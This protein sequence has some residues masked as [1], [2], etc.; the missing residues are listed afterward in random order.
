MTPTSRHTLLLAI[1]A[2]LAA[3]GDGAER[4]SRAAPAAPPPATKA[5]ATQSADDLPEVADPRRFLDTMPLRW[6]EWE[7]SSP[8]DRA[9]RL[10]ELGIA[11]IRRDSATGPV[12]EGYDPDGERV[13]DFHFVDF[14]GDGVADVIYDGAWFTVQEGSL[15]ALEGTHVKLYH[16]IGGRAVPVTEHHGSVQRIWKGGPGE[17]LSFRTMHH[18]CCA[19]PQWSLTFFRP[20]RRGD[21]V[22]YEP[23]RHVVGR[24]DLEIPKQFMA[25][26]RRFTVN[27]DGYL[28]RSTP[29][30]AGSAAGW[31]DG[32][33][34][35]AMAVYGQGARGTAVAERRDTTGRVWWFVRMDGRTPPREAQFED[36]PKSR[37]PT[38]RLGWMSS[39]FL[40]V[41]P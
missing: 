14:S 5:A 30:I 40:T 19:D 25:P 33:G 22:R 12:V 8:A 32:T 35:N 13:E 2:A 29:R 28:L 26:P 3:C 11:P 18:G 4:P 1:A 9:A 20:Q 21:T 24:E 17:P 34:G 7:T 10:R 6:A 39:R 36:D 37:T 23:Y 41:V 27:Q 16:V 31:D 15:G 38:D